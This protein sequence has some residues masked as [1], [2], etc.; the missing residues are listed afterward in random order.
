MTER[1]TAG[2]ISNGHER[3]AVQARKPGTV[4]IAAVGDFHCGQ[5]DVGLYRE[6]FA[7]VNDEAEVLVLTGDLTRWGALS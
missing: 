2:A 7:R 1:S 3:R 6:L 5:D 4:R